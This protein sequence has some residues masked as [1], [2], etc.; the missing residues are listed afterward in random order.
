[1]DKKPP[2][3]RFRD[4]SIVVL[5]NKYKLWAENWFKRKCLSQTYWRTVS[6]AWLF[7]KWI[8]IYM[9][10]F[11]RAASVEMRHPQ[12]PWHDRR[13]PQD[14]QRVGCCIVLSMWL[15]LAIYANHRFSW[16]MIQW[17]LLAL[18]LSIFNV[19]A[20]GC[21]KTP[22]ARIAGMTWVPT[23]LP[24]LTLTLMKMKTL[25][26]QPRHLCDTLCRLDFSTNK[27]YTVHVTLISCHLR[28]YT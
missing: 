19:C 23:A 8:Y 18:I 6:F 7:R 10:Q 26:R 3:L 25:R 1:M 11:S 15:S 2:V 27:T 17:R 21:C 22:H 28:A 4:V 14:V 16:G 24:L 12:Y 13:L 5:C 20:P 9:F